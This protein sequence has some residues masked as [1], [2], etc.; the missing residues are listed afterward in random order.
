MLCTKRLDY[1][2]ILRDFFL[3]ET[4]RNTRDARV[5][6]QGNQPDLGVI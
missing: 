2:H 5:T 4:L 3:V 6:N 1:M